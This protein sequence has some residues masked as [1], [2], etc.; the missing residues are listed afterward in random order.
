MKSRVGTLL[1]FLLGLGGGVVA[2]RY[3]LHDMFDTH[4]ADIIDTLTGNADKA[5]G[6][7]AEDIAKHPDFE[8]ELNRRVEEATRDLK[9]R[10]DEAL[11][12]RLPLPTTSR[13]A[14][15]A[16][17]GGA[18]DDP[19]AG[20]DDEPADMPPPPDAKE[21][22]SEL[23]ARLSAAWKEL[24]GHAAL[25]A[26]EE[27]EELGPEYH[28]QLM[29]AWMKLAD[30]FEGPGQM[31][32]DQFTWRKRFGGSEELLRKAIT[33]PT[34]NRR[35]RYRAIR[36]LPEREE[37]LSVAEFL[38]GKI[39]EERDE[40]AIMQMA[41]TLAA[42]GDPVAIEPLITVVRRGFERFYAKRAVVEALGAFDDE[43]VLGE[44]KTVRDNE[45][46][47]D[48]VRRAASVALLR[49]DPP[50]SG[51]LVL[52]ALPGN[53]GYRAGIRSGD[54][55]TKIDGQPLTGSGPLHGVEHSGAKFE[56]FSEGAFK[57]ITLE[58]GEMG[59]ELKAVRK[60]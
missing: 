16:A 2:E 38:A 9:D 58:R 60:R 55:L 25:D 24:D 22:Y 41:E 30:D 47:H 40:H 19:L 11:K 53:A 29:E 33:D 28:A 17:G 26:L 23:D 59:L 32:I 8:K 1:L 20:L 4:D 34:S 3:L 7:A 42:I 27:M 50:V 18:D 48:L 15:S 43:R 5:T 44:L 31:G 35:F 12:E 54:I 13:K 49:L 10:L 6:R 57:D 36:E 45:T 52:A 51:M 37:S 14:R 39:T 21:L 56:V 46:E